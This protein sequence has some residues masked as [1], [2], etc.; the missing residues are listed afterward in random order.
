M[1]SKRRIENPTVYFDSGFLSSYLLY[2]FSTISTIF[3]LEND[4]E[5]FA[6]K[7]LKWI[8]GWGFIW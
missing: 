4:G 2:Y 7:G 3:E 6:S 1:V 5:S 8:D